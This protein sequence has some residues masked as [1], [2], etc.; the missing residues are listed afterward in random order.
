MRESIIV[1]WNFDDKERVRSGSKYIF[2]NSAVNDS[3][4]TQE[5]MQ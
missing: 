1:V 2:Y 5:K 4:I 3:S